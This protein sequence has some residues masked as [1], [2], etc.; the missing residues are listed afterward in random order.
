MF[1]ALHAAVA[2]LARVDRIGF[3]LRIGKH[4]CKALARTELGREERARI[5]EFSET[6]KER[7]HAVVHRDIGSRQT[8]TDRAAPSLAE[9]ARKRID[10]LAAVEVCH[11]HRLVAVIFHET[12][13][14]PE[15][16]R[17]V[18]RVKRGIAHGRIVEEL[19]TFFDTAQAASRNAET[20]DDHG[21]RAREDVARIM[22]F[23]NTLP[24]AHGGNAHDIRTAFLRFGLDFGRCQFSEH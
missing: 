4:D 18:D 22:L 15:H 14:L 12:V 10:R 11:R 7:R 20:H 8:G 17:P 16:H 19:R 21:L 2:Y 24:T 13:E 9:V 5:P 1:Y 23:V 3:K 6:C